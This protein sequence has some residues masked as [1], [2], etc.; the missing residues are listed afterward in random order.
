MKADKLITNEENILVA[1]KACAKFSSSR[2][3]MGRHMK[4]AQVMGSA[5]QVRPRHPDPDGD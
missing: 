1:C 2:H 5:V 3:G 4:I